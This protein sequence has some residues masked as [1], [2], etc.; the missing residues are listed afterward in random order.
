MSRRY[1]LAAVVAGSATFAGSAHAGGFGIPEIGVRRTGMAAVV[2]R[3][4]EP[5]S[6][7]HNPGGLVLQKGWRVYLSA[8]GSL[9]S[10]EFKLLPWERSDE[11][12][13]TMPG[14]DGYYPT[15]K[16][17]RAFGAAPMLA[18]TGELIPDRLVVAMGAWIGNAA[19][20]QFDENDITRYHLINGYIIAPQAVIGGAYRINDKI[21]VG[22]NAGV[23]YLTLKGEREFYP[24]YS[25]TDLSGIAGTRPLLELE[26]DAWSPT[27]SVGVY[28]QPH[29]KVT[30]GA[31]IISRVDATL[32]GP[33]KVTFSDDAPSPGDTLESRHKTKQ[34][35]PWTFL[36]GVNVDVHP[37]VE[38]GAELR[39]WLYRQYDE[40]LSILSPRL[41]VI[42]ELKTLKNYRDSFQVSGGIRV[43]SLKQ[44]PGLEMMLGTHFDRTPAPKETVTLDQPT[45]NHLGLHSGLRYTHGSL[46]LGASY[47]RYWYDIPTVTTST[48]FPPSNFKGDGVNNS[49]VVSMEAAL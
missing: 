12:L 49:L 35:L 41:L 11:F 27:W 32:E 3:P 16:P 18:I 2:G 26:G 8:T 48:T 22:A 6:L 38:L 34:L 31:T 45:F 5:S 1:L 17:T 43:H 4:D 36:G 15:V 19:G 23:V 10:T 40:Q 47:F 33:V 9:I 24:I 46:R 20:A 14:P 28:G 29:K 37:N 13:N 7:F 25:G 44:A 39:W 42:S 21:S 30:F